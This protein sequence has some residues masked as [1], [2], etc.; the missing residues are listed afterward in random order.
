MDRLEEF[1][2]TRPFPEPDELV[3]VRH[4]F[5]PARNTATQG[6]RAGPARDH[7]LHDDAVTADDH[8]PTGPGGVP[9]LGGACEPV[10]CVTGEGGPCC[11]EILVR[12]SK[13]V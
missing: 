11:C 4:H 6:N 8:P 13:L 1:D 7:A 5:L 3:Q 12:A 9:P 2:D 10:P